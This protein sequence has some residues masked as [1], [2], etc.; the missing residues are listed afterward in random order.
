MR[1]IT[2]EYKESII[3]SDFDEFTIAFQPET[4]QIRVPDFT[5]YSP[6]SYYHDTHTI[7]LEF[8]PEGITQTVHGCLCCAIYTSPWRRLVPD[9][10]ANIYYNTLDIT[11]ILTQAFTALHH[12]QANAL[13]AA[14]N[15]EYIGIECHLNLIKIRLFIRSGCVKVVVASIRGATMPIPALFTYIVLIML[16]A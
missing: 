4:S 6:G 8:H 13:G 11:E 14:D 1:S 5:L 3:N 9:H 2:D 10:A 16:I 7:I 15:A 12:V